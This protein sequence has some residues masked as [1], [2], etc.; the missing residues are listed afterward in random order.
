MS[1]NRRDLLLGVAASSLA[2][3]APVRVRAAAVAQQGWT[4]DSLGGMSRNV[5]L[6]AF[7]DL[8]GTR[9]AGYQMAMQ[10]SGGRLYLYCAH[11]AINGITV[12][13]V[14]EPAKPQLIRFV[15]EPS[16]RQGIAMVKL[17]VADGIGPDIR[18]ATPSWAVGVMGSL[19]PCSR[20]S[21]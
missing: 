20:Q 1:I 3:A 13:D 8:G 19:S 6:V 7:H 12:M 14:T 18:I 21:S 2:T 16:G 17:Q 15:P 5:E 11:W 10:E 9:H 4:K